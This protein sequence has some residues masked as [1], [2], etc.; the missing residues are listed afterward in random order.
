MERYTGAEAFLEILNTNGISSVF[1]NPGGDVCPVQAAVCRY[2]V[3]GKHAPDM[4]L[5]LHESVA[6]AAAI[7]HYM[8]SGKP[9]AVMVHSELG[10]LQLAGQVHNAQWGRTPVV[11]LAQVTAGPARTDWQKQ[12]FDQRIMLRNFVKWDVEIGPR[13]NLHEKLQQAFDVAMAE[14][15]GPVYVTFTHEVFNHPFDPADIRKPKLVFPAFPKADPAVLTNIADILLHAH[16]PLI[17]AGST[18]RYIENIRALTDL[19]ET[20]AAPV[21]SG[22]TRMNFPTTHPLCAGIEHIGGSRGI[23]TALAEAD[24]ILSLDYDMPYVPAAGSPKP[25]AGILQ[26]DVDPLTVGRPLWGRGAD[27][28]L[29]ADSREA[30]PALVRILRQHITPAKKAELKSR[31]ALLAAKHLRER[32]DYRDMA[33]SKAQDSPVSPDWLSYCL[34][35]IMGPDTILVNH[36]ISQAASP[37]EQIDRTEPFSLLACAGGNIGFAV[38]AALGA[39]I[40][41]PDKTVVSLLTDGGFYWGCPVSAL[42]SARAYKAPVLYVIFNNRS[43]G[44]IRQIVESLSESKISDELGFASGL[45]IDP[46]VDSSLVARSCGGYGRIVDDPAKVMPV[47]KTALRHVQ[48]GRSAIVDVMLPKGV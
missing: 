34:A 21:M 32:Q 26:V 5:C 31:Y 36:L 45:D 33:L 35:Q 30:I 42:W 28:F 12:P 17:V 43:Y 29:Q 20:L 14:P 22:L 24:V 16:H 18:G 44:A 11:I 7:G 47:L 41:A 15:R 38:G 13:D 37:T 10:T 9:Q 8:V 2:R 6:L 27:I 39:K 3:A 1:F 19:A 48:N 40:A 4:V 25:D 23:N 46:P